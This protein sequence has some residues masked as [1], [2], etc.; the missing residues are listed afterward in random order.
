MR[1]CKTTT[2]FRSS[3]LHLT[4]VALC[5]GV[6]EITGLSQSSLRGSA[7]VDGSLVVDGVMIILTATQPPGT[8]A[9]TPQQAKGTPRPALVGGNGRY[10]IGDLE[11]GTYD[12][13]VIGPRIK[14]HKSGVVIK[15][16]NSNVVDIVLALAPQTKIR[17]RVVSSLGIPIS[18]AKVAI[19][20]SEIPASLCEN[21]PIAVAVANELGETAFQELSNKESYN[22]V[23]TIDSESATGKM[24]LVAT[25]AV[26]IGD[27]TE[28]T[29]D[30]L[31]GEGPSPTLTARMAPD[32]RVPNS[33]ERPP[34]YAQGPR[35]AETMAQTVARAGLREAN[36][37][38]LSGQLDE[39][40][41]VS[42]A[43]RGG[44]RAA[45]ET[46]DAAVAGVNSSNERISALEDYEPA[47]MA[48]VIFKSGS[49]SLSS[50]SKTKLDELAA[51]AQSSSG[52]VLAVSGYTDAL[53]NTA[54][55]RRL[56]QRRTD[57]VIRYLT[58]R[59]QIPLRRMLSPDAYGEA[60]PVADNTTRAGRAVNRRVEIKVLVSRKE[61]PPANL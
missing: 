45:Q 11:P 47:T 33:Q 22:V 29:I 38:R 50:D 20:S 15:A 6:G 60:N 10:R 54:T 18:K 34:T 13:R 5:F 25:E 51:L 52:Y 3:W 16:G 37:Q 46:A 7:K 48:T 61:K 59:H 55:N 58:K 32:T 27:Q 56:S 40:A 35:P 1:V 26:T 41:A 17:N 24:T 57:A 36:A 53:G 14:P 30:L 43:A 12:L 42:N 19:Y 39:L 21:C 2:F 4:I 44:S 23:V 9:G 49:A 31:V 28:A 8:K